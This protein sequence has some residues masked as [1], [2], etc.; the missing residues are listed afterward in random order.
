MDERDWLAQRFQEH[1]PRMRALAYRM[2]GSTSEA[3]DALQ[4]AWIRLSRSNAAE[5]DNIEAWLITVVGRVALNMLRSRKTR[6]EEPLDAH[7]PDPI[8]D[9]A[10]GIDPEHE[11]LL[12]DSVGLALLV[13]LET[14]SPAERLAYVL[15]DMFAVPFDEIGAILERS[16]EAARQLASRGRRRIRSAHTIPDADASAH[17]EVVEAFLSAARDGEFDALVAML[18]PDIVVRE[19]TGSGTIVEVRGASNVARRALAA[20]SQRGL[21]G[22]PALINGAPGWVSVLDGELFAIAALTLHNGRIT[23]MDILLDPARL[24]RLDLTDFDPRL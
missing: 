2:L 16:P 21:V 13:V 7:L 20:A 3:D 6:G 4:E 11:A 15:H 24:A 17:Q 23:T 14:L 5:I 18:D 10:D 12:A 22:R 19:D 8:V 9:R 1:R